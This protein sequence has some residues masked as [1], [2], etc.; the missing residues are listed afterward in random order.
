MGDGGAARWINSILVVIVFFIGLHV[1]FV[2]FDGNPRNGIVQSVSS[3]ARLFMLPFQG[4]FDNS[5][6]Q[7]RRL[8]AALISVIA[9]CLLAGIALA[10]NRNVRTRL[11]HRRGEAAPGAPTDVDT[12]HRV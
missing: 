1:L 2:L 12:T 3:V 6:P 11:A 8:I 9:Y 4:I 7:T 5:N 10:I